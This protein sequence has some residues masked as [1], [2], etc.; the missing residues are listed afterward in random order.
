MREG[1]VARA[2]T[3]VL[4]P[5]RLSKHRDYSISSSEGVGFECGGGCD[6]IPGTFPVFSYW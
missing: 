2:G 6:G 1:G 4:P 5:S 3:A